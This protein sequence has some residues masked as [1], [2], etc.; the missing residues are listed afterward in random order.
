MKDI[1]ELVRRIA[2]YHPNSGLTQEQASKIL[3]KAADEIERLRRCIEH[4][5]VDLTEPRA[6]MEG[7]DPVKLVINRMKW[8][9]EGTYK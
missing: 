3:Y 2:A 8:T 9:L 4:C 7:R 5:L 6:S 1:V